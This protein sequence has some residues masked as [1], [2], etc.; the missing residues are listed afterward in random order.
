MLRRAIVSFADDFIEI[1]RKADELVPTGDDRREIVRG[2]DDLR[3]DLIT[4]T[5]RRSV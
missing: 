5:S 3:A 2:A 1:V 4:L